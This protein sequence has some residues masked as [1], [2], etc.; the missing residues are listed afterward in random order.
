[1]ASVGLQQIKADMT[2]VLVELRLQGNL[3]SRNQII[4]Q[5]HAKN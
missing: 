1:M 5:M 4:I 3:R 2:T